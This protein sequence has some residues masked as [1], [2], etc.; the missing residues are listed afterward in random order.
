MYNHLTDEQTAF[1]ARLNVHARGLPGINERFDQDSFV[2]AVCDPLIKVF[3]DPEP[4]EK[5][6]K[7]NRRIKTFSRYPADGKTGE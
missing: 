4:G 1:M 6:E 2:T 5:A 3:V 7:L